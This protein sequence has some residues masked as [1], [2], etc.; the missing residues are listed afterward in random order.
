MVETEILEIERVVRGDEEDGQRPTKTGAEEAKNACED[1]PSQ[2]I[3]RLNGDR[4][5]DEL[6]PR[7]SRISPSTVLRSLRRRGESF[8]IL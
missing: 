4:F 8:L 3:G 6:L 7:V 1:S 2:E 5:A